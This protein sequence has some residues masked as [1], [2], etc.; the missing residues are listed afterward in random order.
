[1]FISFLWGFCPGGFWQGGFV[2]GVFVR[3]FCPGCFC[4]DTGQ[5]SLCHAKIE[6][7]SKKN[8]CHDQ[9]RWGGGTIFRFY[10]EDIELSGG[11]PS[12]PH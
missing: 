5:I 4:P 3:G 11:L 2:Q 7:I 8:F 9:Q 1:M 10:G 6:K 12:P